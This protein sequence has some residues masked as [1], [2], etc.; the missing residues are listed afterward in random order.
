MESTFVQTNSVRLH[1]LEYEGS[2]P[3]II[4]MHGLTANAHAF[5]GLIAAGLSPAFRVIS[6]D[7]RGRGQSEQPAQGYSMQ[8][9]AK[10]II[11][12]MDALKI[13]KAVIGGHSFGALVTFYLAA[14]YPARV[15]KMILLDVAANMHPDAKEMLA[16]ALSRL[17]K[18][19]DSF[20]AYLEKVK[21]APYLNFWDLAMLSYYTADVRKNEDGS[22]ICI[23]GPQQIQQAVAAAFNEPWIEYIKNMNQPAILINGPDV[24]T[25]N[26]PLVP[27]KNAME[28]VDM[29]KDCMY[30]KVPGNHQTMLYGE[31][32]IEIVSIIRYFLN[33]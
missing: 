29:M 21:Q 16:P 31:G 28:M 19:Y 32:A 18:H 1:Y 23:P 11:G 12:L 2:G 20:E 13:E 3:A 5:D 25:M 14:R 27:E 30:A 8:E 4:L 33:K 15:E 24:Y 26:A 6:V 7:L 17:G 10:D 9:H 22:V